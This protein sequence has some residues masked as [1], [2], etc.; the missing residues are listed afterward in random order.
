MQV[1]FPI[2]G[3]KVVH[4]QVPIMIFEMKGCIHAGHGHA[5]GDEEV[6]T[7]KWQFKFPLK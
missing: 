1:T 5:F 7:C 3:M 2:L 6:H 4:R